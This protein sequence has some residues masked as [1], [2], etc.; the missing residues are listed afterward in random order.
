MR[1]KKMQQAGLIFCSSL[2]VDY[3][4]IGYDLIAFIGIY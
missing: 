2:L 4:K 1:M 3:R